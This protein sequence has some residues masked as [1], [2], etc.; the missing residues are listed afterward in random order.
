MGNPEARFP[1]LLVDEF[2]GV[3]LRHRNA[4]S[5]GAKNQEMPLE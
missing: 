2:S 5:L 4:I 1:C 3:S